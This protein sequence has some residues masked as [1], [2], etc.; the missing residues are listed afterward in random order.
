M[1]AVLSLRRGPR[2]MRVLRFCWL[3]LSCRIEAHSQTLKL[4]VSPDPM[5]V[6]FLILV[7]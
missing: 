1:F 3:S 6:W 4:P 7:S 5:A 2:L